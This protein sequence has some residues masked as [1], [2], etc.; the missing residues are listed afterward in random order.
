MNT[1][2]F[3]HPWLGLAALMPI[4]FWWWRRQR[5]QR[6]AAIPFSDLRLVPSMTSWRVSTRFVVPLLFLLS[7]WLLSFALSGPRLGHEETKVTTEGIAISM[8]IDVSNSMAEK[9]MV[10]DG[11]AWSRYDM[12]RD[13]FRRFVEG[14][15]KSALQGRANDMVSLVTFGA[16]V[17]DLSPLTLDHPFVLELLNNTVARVQKD[18]AYYLR[19]Q[20]QGNRQA[21]RALQERQPI[22]AGTAVY[23]GVAL[24]ADMLNRAGE[25]L[26][27]AVESERANYTLKSRVMILLTD[28]DDN[29]SGISVDEAISVAQEFDVKVHVVHIRG[30]EVQQDIMGFRITG[31]QVDDRALRRIAD[32]TGGEFFAATESGGLEKVMRAIDAMEKSEIHQQV[33][34]H[35][36][37]WHRPWLLA[38]GVFFVLA[39]V[40]QHTL[41]RELP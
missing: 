21:M 38:G 27:E 28:G 1:L 18:H 33:S 39:L 4:F 36:T 41:Y 7:W 26:D 13:L 20:Q 35:H 17:D 25:A 34:M 22:W 8:V 11:E 5:S 15:E 10:V 29:S 3:T 32:E 30:R 37:P 23:E 31:S 24:G 9:D 12:V 40:L 16:W 19:I 2:D 6:P 14:D